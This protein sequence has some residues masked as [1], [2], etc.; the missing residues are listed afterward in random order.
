[1]LA[2]CRREA[3]VTIARCTLRCDA[4]DV[5]PTLTYR[6]SFN[7][8][9]KTC[10]IQNPDIPRAGQVGARGRAAGRGGASHS[11]S[12]HIEHTLSRCYGSAYGGTAGPNRA[13]RKSRQ[14]S[15]HRKQ[16]SL[17]SLIF[18]MSLNI[19]PET[20]KGEII[21]KQNALTK[22]AIRKRLIT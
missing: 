21:F 13:G 12:P 17:D 3:R 4:R 14:N 1:M 6:L 2:K 7:L 9:I 15:P 11:S 5:P 16:G 22:R 10:R 8:M 19:F 18:C 20:R